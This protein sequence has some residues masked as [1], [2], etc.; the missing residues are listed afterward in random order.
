MKWYHK[1]C[2]LT[3]NK[4]P[5][6]AA[7]VIRQGDRPDGCRQAGQEAVDLMEEMVNEFKG[8]NQPELVSDAIGALEGTIKKIRDGWS[9]GT[10][11]QVCQLWCELVFQDELK[12]GMV[13]ERE[14]YVHAQ[15]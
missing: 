4:C 14:G 8:L 13:G 9:A 15:L 7:D 1:P 12:G 10:G 3:G 6:S 5:A 11:S 2:G